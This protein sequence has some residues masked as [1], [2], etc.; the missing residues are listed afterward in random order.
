MLLIDILIS[1]IKEVIELV[2][3]IYTLTKDKKYTFKIKNYNKWLEYLESEFS[4]DDK[5]YYNRN[6]L[7]ISYIEEKKPKFARLI[8]RI[9]ELGISDT[10]PEINDYKKIIEEKSSG[11]VNTSLTKSDTGKK[12]YD[13]E[14]V[15]K[16]LAEQG[17]RPTDEY[18]A[19]KYDLMLLFG[20]GPSNSTKMVD[21]GCRLE[22]LLNEWEEY[23]KKYDDILMISRLPTPQNYEERDFK[24]LS[25][26]DQHKLK[27]KMLELKLSEFKWLKQITHHQLMGVKYFHHISEKIPRAEVASSE[28]L[29]KLAARIINKDLIVQ[30]CGSYR[31]GRERSGDID[32]SM[33]HPSLKTAEQL[34]AYFE[35][36]SN[37]LQKYVNYLTDKVGF[38]AD[39]LSQNGNSKYMGFCKIPKPGYTKYRRIDIRFVPYNSYGST[40][41]YFTGSKNFN[42]EMRKKAI[43]MNMK[44]NEYGLFKK[45]KDKKTNKV[46]S[47]FEHIPTITEEDV[48]KILNMEYKTPK[49]RDI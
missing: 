3:K 16:K 47:D 19:A 25:E 48:F 21:K 7:L 42:T 31:R 23:V 5:K 29:L 34:K 35:T 17:A 49:E 10:L 45:I 6:E 37:I 33:C 44:L 26:S 40:I 9:K 38:I 11:T 30:C 13:I 43:S 22:F 14:A 36:K 46:I 28:K 8:K 32:V 2:G 39:H 12:L 1:N 27:E 18:E 41:L 24:K 20:F 15:P 4:E